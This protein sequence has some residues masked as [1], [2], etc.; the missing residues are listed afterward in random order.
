MIYASLKPIRQWHNPHTAPDYLIY[1]T[2]SGA[3][4]FTALWAGWFGSARLIGAVALVAALLAAAAKSPPT[5]ATS[6]SRHLW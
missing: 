1:A 2:F 3:V 4:L 5:G 6:I